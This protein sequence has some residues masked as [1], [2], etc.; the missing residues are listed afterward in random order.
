MEWKSLLQE[1][2]ILRVCVWPSLVH[3][4]K[5]NIIKAKKND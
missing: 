3:S 5:K 1:K 2:I 4:P